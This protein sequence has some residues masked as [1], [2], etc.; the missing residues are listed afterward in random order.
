MANDENIT[1]Q[2]LVELMHE[3]CCLIQFLWDDDDDVATWSIPTL[4]DD[5]ETREVTGLISDGSLIRYLQDSA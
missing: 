3:Q 1:A 5:C 4:N 2:Q